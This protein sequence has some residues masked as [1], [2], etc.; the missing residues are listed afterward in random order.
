MS[1]RALVVVVALL[2][3][4]A[5]AD[6]GTLRLILAAPPL[7]IS[8]FTAPEPLRVG[9]ADV[10]VLVQDGSAAGPVLLDTKIELRLRAP[11][12]GSRTLVP[13]HAAAANRLFQSALVELSQPGR[14]Q[15]TVT[16]HHDHDAATVACDVLV[17][18]RAPR[19]AAAWPW[20]ALPALLVAMFLWRQRLRG[21]RRSLYRSSRSRSAA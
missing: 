5:L 9:S 7:V 16:V 4:S 1:W 14:W 17:G 2:P 19:L 12:G 13:S 6:G 21:R 18:S 11:N 3:R 8:V 10:S 20:L 15:L